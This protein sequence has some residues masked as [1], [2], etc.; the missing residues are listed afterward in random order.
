LGGGSEP[1]SLH[2]L[3]AYQLQL[4]ANGGKFKL[5]QSIVRKF[6]IK[7]AAGNSNLIWRTK[8]NLTRLEGISTP[9]QT[10]ENI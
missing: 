2:F 1:E 8:L 5:Y 7:L 6:K 10:G 4:L 9:K 3:A